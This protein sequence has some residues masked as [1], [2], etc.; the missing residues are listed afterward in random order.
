[1]TLSEGS[2]ISARAL[3]GGIYIDLPDWRREEWA[4]VLVRARTSGSVNSITIGLHPRETHEL[5]TQMA[6]D[7]SRLQGIWTP[8]AVPSIQRSKAFAHFARN[9]VIEYD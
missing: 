6:E 1:M 4:E 3:A 5:R 2:R 7:L 8:S 9:A